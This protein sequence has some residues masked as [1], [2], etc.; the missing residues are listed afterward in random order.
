LKAFLLIF[1]VLF[2][3]SILAQSTVFLTGIV[4]SSNSG[5]AVPSDLIISNE[6][7]NF[8][9]STDS[10]GKFSCKIPKGKIKIEINQ[11]KFLS[12]S[13]IVDI[14]KDTLINFF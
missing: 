7:I 1:S 6:I 4:K 13:L 12:E 14:Q 11:I 5:I 2:C 9:I 10:S 3:Q 8:T